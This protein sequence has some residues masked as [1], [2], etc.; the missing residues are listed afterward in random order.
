MAT[1]RPLPTTDASPRRASALSRARAPLAVG[2]VALLAT[3]YVD[4]VDPNA[5]GHYPLCPTKAVTGLD[6]PGCGGLRAVHSLT[7]G[8]VVG[9]VDHNAFVVLVLLPVAV[10][11]WLAWLVRSLRGPVEDADPAPRS[12]VERLADA[13]TSRPAVVAGVVV[14]LAF[15]VVRNID[16]LP[17]LA[18]LGSGLAA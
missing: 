6:C 16:A 15:T 1:A 7:H 9:A 12:R 3:A 11:L 13:L 17:A 18:W 4:L 8:D 10:V 5:P 14:M 2:A